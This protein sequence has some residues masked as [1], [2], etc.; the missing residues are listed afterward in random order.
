MFVSFEPMSHWHVSVHVSTMDLCIFLSSFHKRIGRHDIVQSS[1]A[2]IWCKFVALVQKHGRSKPRMMSVGS[3][4]LVGA[5]Y[6]NHLYIANLGDS[7]VVL[8]TNKQNDGMVA[9][10]LSQEHNASYAEVRDEL[11]AQHPD[12]SDIV[13]LKHGVWRV[14]GIIQ[15]SK[16]QILRRI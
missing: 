13:T 15:V 1:Q 7:R 4:C 3:C 10:R 14:K 12:D 9:V 5:I 8:G 16:K 11:K 6:G 2:S